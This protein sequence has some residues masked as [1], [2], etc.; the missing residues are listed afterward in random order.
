V[1]VGDDP[2]PNGLTPVSVSSDGFDCSMSA[3]GFS[4]TRDESIAV[5]QT[6]NIT[7]VAKTD[8]AMG[9]TT[10][11]NV[12]TVS[13]PGDNDPGDNSD[14]EDTPVVARTLSV[15]AEAIC[16]SDMPIVTYTITTNF[17]PDGGPTLT[18][19]PS[20]LTP[21][22]TV[23]PEYTITPG[24]LFV[25]Q[26]S[27]W[28]QTGEVLWPGTVVVNGTTVDWPGWDQLPDG[29][30]VQNPNDVGGNLRPSATVRVTVNPTVESGEVYP[31]STPN[32]ATDPRTLPPTLPPT[33]SD[34][35]RG[36]QLALVA[37]IGGLTLVLVARR[38]RTVEA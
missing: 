2:L 22:Q 5:G 26:G 7:I 25:Q 14:P 36:L 35:A 10:V 30:W 23:L 27:S 19:I 24:D 28:V 17:D 9:N 33:G 38:R 32:C 20:A 15:L 6:I 11:T 13:T 3:T 37:G 1:T 12:A 18:F 4:C 34:P 29:S 31:P 8:P 16:R 21:N